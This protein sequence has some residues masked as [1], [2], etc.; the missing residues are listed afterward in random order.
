M[1][2]PHYDVDGRGASLV[3]LSGWGMHHGVLSGLSQQLKEHYQVILIDLPGHGRSDTID[4]YTSET[5]IAAILA[6]APTEPCC[7]IGWSLGGNLALEIASRYPNR[8]SALC[9]MACN[10]CFMAQADWP[11]VAESQVQ[12]LRQDLLKNTEAALLRFIAFQFQGLTNV[13]KNIHRFKENWSQQ[14]APDIKVLIKALQLL[15]EMD[16][17]NNLKQLQMPA[18]MFLGSDDRLVPCQIA[19]RIRQLNPLVQFKIIH[20]AGHALFFSHQAEVAQTI[21]NFFHSNSS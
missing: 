5:V 13:K 10:P 12:S 18:T 17:R 14:K 19:D 6:E 15:E 7:W 9:L 11:G 3:L 4:P 16:L 20:G 2:N 21:V 8:V 1:G